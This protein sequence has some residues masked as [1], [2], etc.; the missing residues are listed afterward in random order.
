VLTAL[1]IAVLLCACTSS[2]GSSTG[3]LKGTASP[4]GPSSYQTSHAWAIKVVLRRGPTVVATKTVLDTQAAG[5]PI[6]HQIFTFTEPPGSYTISESP[7]NGQ[8]AVIKA[9]TTSTVD[10]SAVCK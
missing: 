1:G 2:S 8:T 10:L 5:Q 4:C 6:I 3:V 7:P 9:E